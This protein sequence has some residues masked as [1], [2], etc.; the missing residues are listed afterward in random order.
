MKARMYTKDKII[1]V[2]WNDNICPI[3]GTEKGIEIPNIFKDLEFEI[4]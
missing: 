4:K 3:N 2:D 1:E